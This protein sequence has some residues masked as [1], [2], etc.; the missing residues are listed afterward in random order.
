MKSKAT[1]MSGMTDFINMS[2]AERE[3]LHR[4]YLQDPDAFYEKAETDRLRAALALSDTERF[5][6][7]TSLM[8]MNR[9]LRHAK[10]TTPGF[11]GTNQV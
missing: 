5:L 11:P 10:I 4:Q 1:P 6:R 2:E 7:M 8:K 9:M 3:S